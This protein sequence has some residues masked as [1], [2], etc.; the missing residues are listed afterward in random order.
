MVII[1][2]K[3]FTWPSAE[4][5]QLLVITTNKKLGNINDQHLNNIVDNTGGRGARS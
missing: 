1:Q 5:D 2:Y 4:A 3:F